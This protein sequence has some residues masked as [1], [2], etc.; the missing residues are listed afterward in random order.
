MS[1]PNRSSRHGHE[2][3]VRWCG[4]KRAGRRKPS[5]RGVDV[6]AA[7]GAGV[8]CVMG[9]SGRDAGAAGPADVG[10][11]DWRDAST[12]RSCG[13]QA[14]FGDGRWSSRALGPVS[15]SGDRRRLRHCAVA[16]R[17]PSAGGGLSP[18]EEPSLNSVDRLR[19][20]HDGKNR[21]S[22]SCSSCCGRGR[23]GARRGRRRRDD[24]RLGR[25][26]RP[27]QTLAD[28]DARRR[29]PRW[30]RWRPTRAPGCTSSRTRCSARP[31]TSDP[32]RASSLSGSRRPTAASPSCRPRS[33]RSAS[34]S[35]RAS[36]R[37]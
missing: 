15:G 23:R 33:R 19:G 4:V 1:G 25:R 28:A 5:A 18:S 13:R 20:V 6:A 22:L 3:S 35:S 11:S 27:G 10:S 36:A 24:R 32:R 29:R 9:T 26:R 7:R 8:A 30:R 21:A 34:C 12:T 16:V 17:W 2:S 37:A 14:P 31:S